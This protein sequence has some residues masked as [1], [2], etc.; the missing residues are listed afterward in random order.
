MLILIDLSVGI[1]P[2]LLHHLC[3]RC[4]AVTLGPRML[5]ICSNNGPACLPQ[6]DFLSVLPTWRALWAAS[7]D[8]CRTCAR[9]RWSRI[10][11]Y[12]IRNDTAQARPPCA[13]Y[14]A[15]TPALA[16]LAPCVC[17]G[18]PQRKSRSARCDRI[19][20]LTSSARHVWQAARLAASRART[21]AARRSTRCVPRACR[22]A[23][24]TFVR[25]H[26]RALACSA[27]RFEHVRGLP[28]EGLAR[29][30]GRSDR[31]RCS[32]GSASG[33]ER[34]IP[35]TSHFIVLLPASP[36]APAVNCSFEPSTARCWRWAVRARG[37]LI[38]LELARAHLTLDATLSAHVHPGRAKRQ[39]HRSC[40][41]C[42]D[43]VRMTQACSEPVRT[44]SFNVRKRSGGSWTLPDT[45]IQPRAESSFCEAPLAGSSREGA[46][47]STSRLVPL[48]SVH[49]SVRRLRSKKWSNNTFK[50]PY[51]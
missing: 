32:P 34:G 3:I 12:G 47:G 5:H 4:A 30:R 13:P 41:P 48:W 11:P 14:A 27:P 24:A 42:N 1:R 40:N 26:R 44:L 7:T 45:P 23:R 46:R 28:P 19:P 6:V 49:R 16:T 50:R 35:L 43:A 9:A 10:T 2:A 38:V 39:P 29:A 22:A 25:V 33:D 18:A 17:G 31:A 21:A 37:C 36:R 20:L 15:R 8:F 51:A